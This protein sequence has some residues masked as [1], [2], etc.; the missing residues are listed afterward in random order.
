MKKATVD[1]K[2]GDVVIFGGERNKVLS[3]EMPTQG[4]VVKVNVCRSTSPGGFFWG[5]GTWFYAGNQ[6][7][8][9][10]ET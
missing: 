4:C 3:L 2:P 5:S 9:D 6:S 1:L 10:V 8:Q 7:V